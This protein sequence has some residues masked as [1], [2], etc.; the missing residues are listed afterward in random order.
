MFL[1]G[2]VNASPDSLNTDS[3]VHGPEQA[4]ARPRQLLADGADGIDLGGQGSTD[5]ADRGAVEG[6][7]GAPARRW[8]RRWPRWACR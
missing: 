8:C 6:R 3:I 4:L 1:Y 7:V 5:I 2:V